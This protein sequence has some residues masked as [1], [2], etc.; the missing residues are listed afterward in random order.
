MRRQ[1]ASGVLRIGQTLARVGRIRHQGVGIVEP[2][3]IRGSSLVG[4]TPECL[5]VG[6]ARAVER[7]IAAHR[8]RLA[9]PC[10]SQC[11]AVVNGV[12]LDAGVGV[13]ELPASTD[14]GKRYHHTG[15]RLACHRIDTCRAV[16]AAIASQ[17]QAT[18]R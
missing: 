8:T 2:H 18:C 15:N 13:L 17:R 12:G 10:R 3:R 7:G 9:A 11:R 1:S 6:I 16:Q 5:G 14:F 4:V